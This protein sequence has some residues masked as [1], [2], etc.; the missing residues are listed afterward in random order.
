MT[1]YVLV[2]DKSSLDIWT[3]KGGVLSAVCHD[4]QISAPGLEGKG[5]V[6]GGH[7]SLD[8]TVPVD[9]L[10][11]RGACEGGKTKP[12]S[13][14]DHRDIEAN[15]KGPAVLDAA[16]F[17]K[18]HYTAEGAGDPLSATAPVEARGSL[19][20]KGVTRPVPVQLRFKKGPQ[21]LE[22]TGEL[23]FKQTTFG[24][25]PYTAMLGAMKVADE[26]RLTWSLALAPSP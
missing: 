13:P 10:Q 22:V 26:V 6:E 23:R 1:R 3:G 8:L 20:I 15:A 4:L 2:A 9:K 24:M 21:R 25:T 17:P 14:Q 12:M 16:R 11:V 19:T 7:F 18:I 5:T